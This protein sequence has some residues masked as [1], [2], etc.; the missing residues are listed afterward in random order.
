MEPPLKRKQHARSRNLDPDLKVRRA[1]NDSQ[2]KSI[3]ESIFDKYSK[4]FEGIGDEIDLRTGEIVVDNGHLFSIRNETDTGEPDNLSETLESECDSDEGEDNE[5]GEKAGK[6]T[7]TDDET[8]ISQ[9]DTTLQ[10]LWAVDSIVRDV[11]IDQHPTSFGDSLT[12]QVIDYNSEEDEL[13][14]KA[15][16]WVTPREARAISH[17]KWQVPDT[18]PTF[19]DESLTEEAWRVPLLPSMRRSSGPSCGTALIKSHLL[20]ADKDSSPILTPLREKRTAAIMETLGESIAEPHQQVE[21]E[22]HMSD[23]ARSNGQHES[24]V[25]VHSLA[26]SSRNKIN[27]PRSAMHEKGKT[28]YWTQEEEDRLRDFKT[29]T[30]LSVKAMKKFFPNRKCPSIS[31]KWHKMLQQDASLPR[32]LR[33]KRRKIAS[34]SMTPRSSSRISL[35]KRPEQKEQESE[36][37]TKTSGPI[38]AIGASHQTCRLT[39]VFLSELDSLSDN[40]EQSRQRILPTRIPGAQSSSPSPYEPSSVVGRENTALSSDKDEHLGNSRHRSSSASHPKQHIDRSDTRVGDQRELLKNHLDSHQNE[41][42]RPSSTTN[43]ERAR[44]NVHEDKRNGDDNLTTHDSKICNNGG[45]SHVQI[46]QSKSLDEPAINVTNKFLSSP[47]SLETRPPILETSSAPLPS[48]ICCPEPTAA[49]TD[50]TKVSISCTAQPSRVSKLKRKWTSMGFEKRPNIQ[51]VVAASTPQ[52]PK[53]FERPGIDACPESIVEASHVPSF[54]DQSDMPAPPPQ[55]KKNPIGSHN[56]PDNKAGPSRA[57][58]PDSQPPSSSPT[59]ERDL[60]ISHA[61]S[62]QQ[63]Q[64]LLSPAPTLPLGIH[65]YQART[66]MTAGV[67]QL[68]ELSTFSPLPRRRS[69]TLANPFATNGR[70][71]GSSMLLTH[72]GRPRKESK[73]KLVTTNTAG[74]FPTGVTDLGDLSEDELSFM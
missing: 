8:K 46:G 1:R 40:P 14:D 59:A 74:S 37:I 13:A 15:V 16:E 62:A 11:S 67:E 68:D 57:E 50:E 32:F 38:K 45:T 9:Q 34:N 66:D 72:R 48:E 29:N 43:I 41:D 26:N 47:G 31:Y 3:F 64:G 42:T 61:I 39:D 63:T 6:D 23:I 71:P 12:E 33:K 20:Q 18:G 17:Q 70:S 54:L 58:I 22:L 10:A 53:L 65:G 25:E 60:E 35:Q 7:I 27:E 55:A 21:S 69:H 56:T 49:I 4:D 51:V 52:T 30:D 73:R 28:L 19:Q 36:P 5:L 44:S 24:I 2:L